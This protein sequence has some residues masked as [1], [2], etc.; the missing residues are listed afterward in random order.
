MQAMKRLNVKTEHFLS[1][2]SAWLQDNLIQKQ[3]IL[4]KISQ[5]FVQFRFKVGELFCFS[6]HFP[7][8]F[9]LLR[10]TTKGI[11]AEG[12]Y[13]ITSPSLTEAL[14]TMPI[15]LPAW[16]SFVFFVSL[17][18]LNPGKSRVRRV[19]NQEGHHGEGLLKSHYASLHH[20]YTQ[21]A[22]KHVYLH[23]CSWDMN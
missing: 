1:L 10:T 4:N 16:K 23:K 12:C 5:W 15:P 14:I 21:L 2:W 3:Y 6:T 18:N 13:S 22:V 8:S 17:Y 20:L 9:Q 11:K 7:Y 19:Q